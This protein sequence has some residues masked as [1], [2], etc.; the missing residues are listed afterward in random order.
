[1]EAGSAL[2][3]GTALAPFR[4]RRDKGWNNGGICPTEFTCCIGIR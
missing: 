2:L 1:V 3:I 4:K